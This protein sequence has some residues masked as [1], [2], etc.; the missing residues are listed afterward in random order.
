[1]Y[2]KTFS[3]L[4]TAPWLLAGGTVADSIGSSATATG[5][6]T[7]PTAQCAAFSITPN[8][9]YANQYWYKKLGPE[10]Q[11]DTF[12]YSVS[13]LF[14]TAADAAAC[15]ALELDLQQVIGGAVYNGGLQMDFADGAVRVWDRAALRWSVVAT[16]ARW[17]PGTWHCVSF[18]L[19]RGEA[20]G[21]GFYYGSVVVDGGKTLVGSFHTAPI[22]PAQPDMLNVAVQLDTNGAKTPYRVMVDCVELVGRDS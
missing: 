10:P 22:D 7:Q 13:F 11:L 18:E 9:P 15:Q 17:L 4:E 21:S 8:D 2:I 6:Q 1:M 3:A 14:P 16:L 5:T 19:F 20:A 12:K